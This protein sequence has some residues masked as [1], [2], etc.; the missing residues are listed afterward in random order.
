MAAFSVDLKLDARWE[1]SSK[2]VDSSTDRHAAIVLRLKPVLRYFSEVQAFA[3]VQRTGYGCW[4]L[5][6][7]TSPVRYE[8]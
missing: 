2:S 3:E 6:E 5:T 4:L 1:N 7:I 8:A